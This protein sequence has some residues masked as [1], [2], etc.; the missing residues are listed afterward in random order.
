[1][2]ADAPSAMGPPILPGWFRE[3]DDGRLRLLASD[4]GGQVV[5][6]RR[7]AEAAHHAVKLPPEG[8]VWSWTVA[9]RGPEAIWL[10]AVEFEGGPV[11]FGH[12]D[13]SLDSP[14]VI[15][16]T[17]DVVPYQVDV[18]GELQQLTTYAFR[19]RGVRGA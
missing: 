13:R 16:E 7:R 4:I 8:R 17:V 1:M 11:V 9:H 10:L 12:A 15:G 3:T 19:P 14:P 5:F 6:P 18:P 2:T